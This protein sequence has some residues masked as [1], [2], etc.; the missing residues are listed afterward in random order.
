MKEKK[1]HKEGWGG[2]QIIKIKIKKDSEKI[3][4]FEHKFLLAQK[5]F[6]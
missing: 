3:I 6:E 2:Q 1:T 4:L 5:D